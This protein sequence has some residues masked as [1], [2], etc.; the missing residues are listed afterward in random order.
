MPRLGR[1]RPSL[2][3]E[4]RRAAARLIDEA[5]AAPAGFSFVQISDTHIGFSKPANPDPAATLTR[6]LEK[7]AALER[8][9][10]FLLHT[11]D[12]TQ[13]SKPK[14]FDDFD[15]LTKAARLDLHCTPGEHDVLDEKNGQAFLDRYG[16]STLGRG[17]RSF[18]QGGVHFVGLVNVLDLKA[19]GMGALG[20]E[21]LAWLANDLKR[22]SAST[23]IVLFAHIP[24]WEASPEWG[25]GTQ[26]AAEALKLLARF[27]SV[28]V[29][30]GHVHQILQKIEGNITFH[31]A[32]ST[33][34]P[35]P[36]PG[37]APAPGPKVVPA[38]E[39]PGALGVTRISMVKGSR[40][41]AIVDETL[42]D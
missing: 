41:L 13:L 27:G 20:A 40:P 36:A 2:D 21:Q 32:R 29:L 38:A 18:D 28:T 39:L 10:A 14:E 31:T 35:Q 5:A 9:P 17:W 8:K 37:S 19:G 42:A 26:G 34:F 12:L 11:G 30:N 22:R 33:A 7:I 3:H 1:N 25:W 6:A 24:L 16:K 23:P 4:G 15:E